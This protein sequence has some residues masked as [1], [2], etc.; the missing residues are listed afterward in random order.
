MNRP[1]QL[2]REQENNN[3]FSMDYALSSAAAVARST[4]ACQLSLLRKQ[5]LTAGCL[6][7]SVDGFPSLHEIP[8]WRLSEGG[9]AARGSWSQWRESGRRAV[10]LSHLNTGW[11]FLTQLQP[12]LNDNSHGTAADAVSDH[13]R[14]SPRLGVNLE[15]KNRHGNNWWGRS[16]MFHC[17]RV[18]QNLGRRLPF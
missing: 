10:V 12:P 9:V 2:R 8:L 17:A 14:V 13:R 1:L 15:R 16:W 11:R 4:L 6:P 3:I 5:E 18:V 7:K